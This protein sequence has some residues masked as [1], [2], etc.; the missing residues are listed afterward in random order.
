[1]DRGRVILEGRT[2]EASPETVGRLISL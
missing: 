2:S 1:M